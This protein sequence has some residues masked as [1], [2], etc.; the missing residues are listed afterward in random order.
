MKTVEVDASALRQVLIAANGS[1]Y[2]IREL[3]ATQGFEG[4]PLDRL[5]RDYKTAV[6]K[7][8]ANAK[9]N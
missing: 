6:S 7:E 1:P 2:M 9:S 4:N 8:K 3:Q 5:M